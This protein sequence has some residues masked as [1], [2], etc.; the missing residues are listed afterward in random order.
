MIEI[1]KKLNELEF[2]VKNTKKMD[3]EKRQ[4]II[5]DCV[6]DVREEVT[7]EISNII[8]KK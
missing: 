8:N 5:Q 6:N 2:V 3:N 1:Q 7:K 4:K